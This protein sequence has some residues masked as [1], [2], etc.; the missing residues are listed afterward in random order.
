MEEPKKAQAAPKSS[1]MN[2]LNNILAGISKKD[3]IAYGLIALGVICIIIGVIL[4]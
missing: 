3:K 1:S 4:W 2:D